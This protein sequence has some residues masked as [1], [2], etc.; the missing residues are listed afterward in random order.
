MATA[1]PNTTGNPKPLPILVMLRQLIAIA[2]RAIVA[3]TLLAIVAPLFSSLIT[4]VH[5]SFFGHLFAK[6]IYQPMVLKVASVLPTAL[7]PIAPFFPLFPL[8]FIVGH[9]LYQRYVSTKYLGNK[10]VYQNIHSSLPWGSIIGVAAALTMFGVGATAL[11]WSIFGGVA[12]ILKIVTDEYNQIATQ[13]KRAQQQQ[14]HLSDV[15]QAAEAR[16]AKRLARSVDDV[17]NVLDTEQ[18]QPPL[19]RGIARAAEEQVDL[20]SSSQA[21][22]QI[23]GAVANEQPL[24]DEQTDR[25]SGTPAAFKK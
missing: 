9:N 18:V 21:S 8:G 6:S 2:M 13:N 3:G 14:Q 5:Q 19:P 24:V 15:K 25:V 17:D 4:G 23:D 11:Q 1:G 12:G 16:R 22:S 10:E 20:T 7:A